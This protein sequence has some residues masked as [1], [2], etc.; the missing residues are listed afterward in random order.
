MRILKTIYDFF[1]L[2]V[3]WGDRKEAWQD[4]KTINNPE[5]QKEMNDLDEAMKK[6][7]DN[8]DNGVY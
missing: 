7:F 4:A 2:W 5:F 8:W 6:H 1:R 3:M